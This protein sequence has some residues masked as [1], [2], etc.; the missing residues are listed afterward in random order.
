MSANAHWIGGGI[1]A[2]DST[3]TSRVWNPATGRRQADLLLAETSDV[4]RAVAAAA[5]AFETWG[6]SSLSTRTKVLLAVR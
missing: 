2:G 3:R 4:D 5:G 6:E 1:T